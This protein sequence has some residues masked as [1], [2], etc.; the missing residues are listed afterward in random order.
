MGKL[1]IAQ[2]L[3]SVGKFMLYK[4]IPKL[5][6]RGKCCEA[7]SYDNRLKYNSD[8]ICIFLIVLPILE[9]EKKSSFV[10]TFGLGA[11]ETGVLLIKLGVYQKTC[12]G[13]PS[14]PVEI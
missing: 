6:Y 10:N 13:I 1:H 11:C 2:V 12:Q 7:L 8:D 3:S 4:N 14:S 5:L 9:E